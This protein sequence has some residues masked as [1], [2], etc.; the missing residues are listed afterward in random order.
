MAAKRPPEGAEKVAGEGAEERAGC[1]SRA[2]FHFVSPLMAKGNREVQTPPSIPLYSL[3]REGVPPP[4][5]EKEPR[6]ALPRAH[7][8]GI[9]PEDL[10]DLAD[11]SKSRQLEEGNNCTVRAPGLEGGGGLDG[12]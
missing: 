10:W 2:I 3:A 8:Q 7:L 12:A 11:K 5:R 4:S 1:L 9:R 6:R